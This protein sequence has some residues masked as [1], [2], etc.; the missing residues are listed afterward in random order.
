HGG[1]RG[2]LAK[3]SLRALRCLVSERPRAL[4]STLEQVAVLVEDVV[5]DLEEQANIVCERAPRRLL[6]LRYLCDPKRARDRGREE[7]ARLQA[8]QRGEIGLATGD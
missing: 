6:A 7:P 4:R 2:D 8:V 5:D 1:V 3:T